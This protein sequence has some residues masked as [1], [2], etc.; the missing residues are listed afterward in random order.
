MGL[1]FLRRDAI[2]LGCP[3]QVVMRWGVV[4]LAESY[5]GGLAG[6][7]GILGA[8]FGAFDG[9]WELWGGF[10]RLT[11]GAAWAKMMKMMEMRSITVL[12]VDDNPGFLRIAA[13]FLEQE[14]DVV[15]VGAAGGGEEA[16]ALA[17]ELEPDVVLVDLAMPGLSGLETMPRL[18][19]MLPGVGIIAL[20]MLDTS[21]YREAALGAEADDFVPKA[22]MDRDL[23]PAIRRVAGGGEEG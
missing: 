14:E 22:G 16:L 18:R 6:V 15:V 1:W 12:L 23:V 13:R 9:A 21:G 19:A 20:T 2:Y 8:G 3:G 11:P 7:R 10:C 4:G 17:R 5:R